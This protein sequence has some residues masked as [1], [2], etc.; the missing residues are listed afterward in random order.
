MGEHKSAT[1]EA[2]NI[3]G[4]SAEACKAPPLRSNLADG[5]RVRRLR[6]SPEIAFPDFVERYQSAVYRVACGIIGHRDDADVI[7]QQVFVKAYFSI[8]SFDGRISLCAW[9][10]RMAFNEC[11]AFLRARRKG[12]QTGRRADRKAVPDDP[13]GLRRDFLN[14]LLDCIPEDER[15]LLLLRE[16]EGYSIAEL[17]YTAGLRESSIKANLLRARQALASSARQ[18]I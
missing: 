16:V 11:Y 6:E 18:P 12:L 3:D 17:A 7:A 15:Y 9:V 5:D 13:I 10:Y 2:P 14:Q 8:R 4:R 1:S